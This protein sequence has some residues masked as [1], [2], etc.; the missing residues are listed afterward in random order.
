MTFDKPICGWFDGEVPARTPRVVL[1]AALVL[2]WALAKWVALEAHVWRPDEYSDAY[3]YFLQAE[4]AALG[5][6]LAAMTPEYPTPAAALLLLP[7]W[8][9]AHDHAGYRL[10]FL[11]LVVAVDAIFVLLL[12][13]RTSAIG[14]VAWV[15]LETLSGRLALLRFD[16]LPAAL[17]G[18]AV[19]ALLERRGPLAGVLVA[20]GTGLKAWPVL[21]APLALGD[22]RDRRPAAWA[23]GASGLVLVLGSVL[24]AGWPRLL[25]PL[26]YQRDRGLQ[27][28]AVAASVPLWQRLGDD[29]FRVDWST[30]NAYEITGP[31]TDSWLTVATVATAV[32]VVAFAV[33]VWW[34][35]RSGADPDAAAHLALFAVAVFMSTSKALSPQYLLWL[36]APA[37]VLVGH[38]WREPDTASPGRTVRATLTFAWVAVLVAL[39]ALVYPTFYDDLL[40]GERLLP[41][42]V[43]AV[44]NAL[45][46]GFAGWCAWAVARPYPPA[47]RSRSTT[48]AV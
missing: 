48:V 28:E 15:L 30:F 40:A 35:L 39:T 47:A 38:A 31:G 44:R 16:V 6:G 2:L 41:V 12:A 3:Y 26:T 10:G 25:S 17:V 24:A 23:F 21:L 4:R 42:A 32:G 43:L 8:L 13:T 27:I 18:A 33:L 46:V 20:L 11:A 37:V 45:L 1:V 9:G 14:V 36:A 19:L 22:R 34:W 29:R 5:G 7:W